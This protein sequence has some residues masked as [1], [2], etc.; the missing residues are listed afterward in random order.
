MLNPSTAPMTDGGMR[1][2]NMMGLNMVIS[3]KKRGG[4]ERRYER[5]VTTLSGSGSHPHTIETFLY[6]R[7]RQ[8]KKPVLYKTLLDLGA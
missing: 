4:R 5:G 6:L 7:F 3:L 1:L 2:A 8:A